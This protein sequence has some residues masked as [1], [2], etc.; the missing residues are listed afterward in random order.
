MSEEI[1]VSVD[2]E[3]ALDVV[4]RLRDAGMEIAQ[5]LPETGVVT[6]FAS[7]SQIAELERVDGVI[8]V[9]AARRFDL[10]PPDSPLQ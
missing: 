4:E 9:E 1:I 7:A 8:A 6:G 3:R 2:P 10:P 5:A